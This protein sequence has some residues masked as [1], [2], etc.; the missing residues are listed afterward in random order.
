MNI[1]KSRIGRNTLALTILLLATTGAAFATPAVYWWHLELDASHSTCAKR[2]GAAIA[3]EIV[4]DKIEKGP[5]GASAWNK[6][7]Y[8]IIYCTA[9]DSKKTE[10]II[11]VAGD[12]GKGKQAKETMEQLRDAMKSGLFE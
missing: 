4:V 2:A 5:N 1:I 10:V 12:P 7:T 3:S 9:K 11:F 6:N 8:M